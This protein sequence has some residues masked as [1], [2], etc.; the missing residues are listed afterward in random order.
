VAT[1]I[2]IDA[3]KLKNLRAGL[4]GSALV[5]GDE[6]YHNACLTWDALTF[7][8][9]PA[10]V[11]LPESAED[12][13]TAVN[14]ARELHLP[15]GVL[16]GGHG[17][18]V[19]VNDALLVNFVRMKG[20]RLDPETATVRAEAGVK[21]AELVP[22]V[23]KYGL[24]PLN[25]FAGTVGVVG[26]LL[27]GG[28]GWLTRQYGAGSASVRS[29]EIVTADGRL[30]QVNEQ[31]Y[32][33]L[34][35][36]LRGGGGNFGIVT[37]IE[38]ALYPVKEVFGGQVSYPIEQAREVIN[39][40]MQWTR[41]VPDA[42]TS[43]FRVTH[44]PPLPDVPPMLRGQ[45]VVT[46]L[47]CFNG[48]EAEGEAWFAPMRTLGTPL[49]DTFAQIPYIEVATI[50]NE[51]AEGSPFPIYYSH[52]T[53]QDF[54]PQDVDS[55]LQVAADPASGLY[56]V[57]MRHLGG[58]LARVPENAMAASMRDV[59]Y[60]LNALAPAPTSELLERGKRSIDR[61]IEALTPA[62]SIQ[63]LYNAFLFNDVGAERT[64]TAFTSANYQRLVALKNT[65]DP[66]NVFRFNNNI[67]PSL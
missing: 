53:V 63:T 59:N 4:R 30:L 1:N 20:I 33:D 16:G 39:S 34:F 15:I 3:Y 55:F 66:Q 22:Q 14:F 9:S 51:P 17:H 26:Y 54:T 65:Y 36:G 42:L 35:W 44:F 38:F 31:S 58:A 10:I 61:I 46:I 50:S 57:E 56:A 29:L 43:T 24:A 25:G 13:C 21:W 62:K 52:S 27:G 49:L 11:V 48:S 2:N 41:S 67:P 12:V 23:H 19:P 7:E 18:P 6:G 32:P 28:F 37:A 64:R 5:P 47:G 60:N 40:Y 45:S 8:Q